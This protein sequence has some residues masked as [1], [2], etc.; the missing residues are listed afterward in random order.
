VTCDKYS[1]SGIC[2]LDPHTSMVIIHHSITAWQLREWQSVW[3][4]TITTDV[5]P[6][7]AKFKL[8]H[9]KTLNQVTLGVELD[10][11]F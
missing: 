7:A 3:S 2:L 1:I 5:L 4:T 8:A 10:P 11:I 6:L 9:F